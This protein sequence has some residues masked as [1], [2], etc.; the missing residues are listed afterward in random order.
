MAIRGT[1]Q[2][3]GAAAH[4]GLDDRSDV[5][6]GLA[7]R[8]QVTY[9]CQRGHTF[10]LTL[11]ATAVAPADW[12]CQ[13]CGAPARPGTAPPPSTPGS[14]IPARHRDSSWTRTTRGAAQNTTPRTPWMMLCERRT[15]QELQVLLDERLALLR[16]G[17]A[18]R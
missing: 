7:A 16:A 15:R 10:A 6:G 13:H 17:R 3:S 9:H 1:T 2:L 14:D 8:R 18:T 11:A 5:S 12:D 4:Y